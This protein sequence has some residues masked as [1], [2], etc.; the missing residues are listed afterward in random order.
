MSNSNKKS[1]H[2]VT[3]EIISKFEEFKKE[4]DKYPKAIQ[5]IHDEERGYFL[6]VDLDLLKVTGDNA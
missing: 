3:T 6:A 1:L 5:L 2:E 4:I